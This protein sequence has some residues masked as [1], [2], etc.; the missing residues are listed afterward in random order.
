M[1]EVKNDAVVVAAVA[2]V[3]PITGLPVAPAF[4]QEGIESTESAPVA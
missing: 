2:A 4:S 1:N 3:D